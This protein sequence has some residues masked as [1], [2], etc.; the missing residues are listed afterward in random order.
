MLTGLFNALKAQC[1][2]CI[3]KS[4]EELEV[5]DEAVS[6]RRQSFVNFDRAVCPNFE[7]KAVIVFCCAYT[8][9]LNLVV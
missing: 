9:M 1:G 3:C 6:C 7:C 4:C 8:G 5:V 2:I